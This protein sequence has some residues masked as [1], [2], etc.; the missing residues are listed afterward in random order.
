MDPIS[1]IQSE[2][3]RRVLALLARGQA[4]QD[5]LAVRLSPEERA[6][7]GELHNWSPKDHVAHNNFWRQDAITRLQAALDGS[8][9]PDTERDDKQTLM[10][11]DRVFKEQRETPWEQLVG[12]TERLRAET[13]VLVQRLSP[14]DLSQRNRYPWQRGGSLETL[15][16]VNWYD[17]PAEHWADVYLSRHEVDRALELRQAVAITV[18]ELFA[19]DPKMQSYMVYKLGG[20]S[21]RSGRSEQAIGAIREALTLNPSLSEQV[22]KDTDLDPLRALP[23]FQ[24]L[25]V[26]GD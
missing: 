1:S 8:E 20:Y 3:H 21:A 4:D 15:V 16:L 12:E 7:R 6:S 24:A 13:V 18:R 22:R 17:H 25:R 10:L 14:D 9:P 11:N 26:P 19:H 23:E 2:A 5:T